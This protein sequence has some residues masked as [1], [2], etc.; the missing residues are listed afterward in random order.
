MCSLHGRGYVHASREINGNK[1]TKRGGALLP[2]QLLSPSLQRVP[3][4]L[5]LGGR[6]RELLGGAVA[7]QAPLS[8]GLLSG[9][10]ALLIA[11][12]ERTQK[13]QSTKSQG[14]IREGYLR[15]RC[16]FPRFSFLNLTISFPQRCLVIQH[17]LSKRSLL[18]TNGSWFGSNS[19]HLFVFLHFLILYFFL[20]IA[21]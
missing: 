18:L 5:P 9:Q 17:E 20:I 16:F 7:V 6:G 1:F 12:S 15:V 11:G 19:P 14:R 10:V 8:L 3:L 2:H 21:V 13:A 4:F